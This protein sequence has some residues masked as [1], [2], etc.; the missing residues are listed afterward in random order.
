MMKLRLLL[1]TFFSDPVEPIHPNYNL[2]AV[3]K[4][5]WQVLQIA[6]SEANSVRQAIIN[7]DLDGGFYIGECCCIK[8]IIAKSL[9]IPVK[10]LDQSLGISLNHRSY[11]E[12]FLFN[13]ME[14]DTP[15][16]N[17]YS[18]AILEWCNEFIAEQEAVKLRLAVE[19]DI[20]EVLAQV[21]PVDEEAKEQELTSV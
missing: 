19:A 21:L 20:E 8:G 1:K 2:E 9:G 15:E 12:N 13:I 5:L 18:R 11:L 17:A 10:K 6:P 14:G 7:G 4:D 16:T 3:K